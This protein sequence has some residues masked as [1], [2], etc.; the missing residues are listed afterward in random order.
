MK[1]SKMIFCIFVVLLTTSCAIKP[2][3][4]VSYVDKNRSNKPYNEILEKKEKYQDY[5]VND[6]I[7]ISASFYNNRPAHY[8]S[9]DDFDFKVG[10]YSRKK[11]ETE[12]LD[13]D[14]YDDINRCIYHNIYNEKITNYAYYNYYKYYSNSIACNNIFIKDKDDIKHLFVRIHLVLDGQDVIKEYTF[15]K[16]IQKGVLRTVI[17]IM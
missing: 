6:D 11:I 10:I 15:T 13:I 17:D 16:K 12:L 4:L 1:V 9:T 2:F 8:I 7:Y 3:R 14:I 5:F